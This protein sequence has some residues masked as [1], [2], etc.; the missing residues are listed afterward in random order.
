MSLKQELKEFMT[1]G[2]VVDMAVGIIIGA[3]FTAI[4]TS[5]VAGGVTPLIGLI[6]HIPTNQDYNVTDPANGAKATFEPGLILNAVISFILV[7]LVVFFVIVKPVAHMR[8]LEDRKKP[9]PPATTTD[10]P[11]C[12]SSINIKA[13]KCPNCTSD[14][15]PPAK[16]LDVDAAP[17]GGSPPDTKAN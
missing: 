9:K 8:A 1:R 12:C 14:L 4:I 6:G 13:T 2:S 10:C 3:A 11:Y 16:S 5:F 15:T 17:S 7:A